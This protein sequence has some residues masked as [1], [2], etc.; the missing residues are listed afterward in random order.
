MVIITKI[1]DNIMVIENKEENRTTFSIINN[2]KETLLS[3]FKTDEYYWHKMVYDDNYIVTYSRGCMHN[4][5]PLKVNVVYSINKGK[6]ID[7]SGREELFE[8]MFICKKCFSIKKIISLLNNGTVDYDDL[9]KY[10]TSGNQ[11][12]T[13]EEIVNY[14]LTTYPDLKEYLN[15]KGDLNTIEDVYYFFYSMHQDLEK[16][17]D[18]TKK[19]V[20]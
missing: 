18:K 5:L 13:H 15:F 14:I 3:S 8:Y 1:N 2:G 12:I 6:I 10:L 17:K 19:L 4:Q 7:F 9:V 20:K 11:D 16:E